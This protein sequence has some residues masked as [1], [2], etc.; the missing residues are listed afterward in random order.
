MSVERSAYRVVEEALANIHKHAPGAPASVRV[1]W[2]EHLLGLQIRDTGTAQPV[3]LNPAG[4]GLVEM[5]ER[6]RLHGGELRTR[7]VP[8]GGFEVMARL[9]L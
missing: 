2:R 7:A 1:I 4:V 8:G 3:E 9:P 6:V 5:R